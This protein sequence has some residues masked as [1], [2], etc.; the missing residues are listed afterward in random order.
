MDNLS[1]ININITSLPDFPETLYANG[2][3]S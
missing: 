1:F 3:F 2:V